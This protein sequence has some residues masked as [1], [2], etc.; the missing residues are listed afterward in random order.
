SD[1]ITVNA[2]GTYHW[3]ANYGGDAKNNKTNNTCN[4][5]NENVLVQ[6]PGILISKD[7]NNQTIV[8]GGTATFHITVTNTGDAILTNVHVSDALAPGCARTAAQIAA[9]APHNSSTFGPGLPA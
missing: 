1:P 3:I 9:I 4:G 2:S 5:A 6:N 8:S 7:P